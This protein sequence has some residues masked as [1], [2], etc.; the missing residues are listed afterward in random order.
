MAQDSIILQEE[1]LTL[2]C[3]NPAQ[4]HHLRECKVKIFW[5]SCSLFHTFSTLYNL[6]ITDSI[7]FVCNRT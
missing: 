2:H 5:S 4:T 6:R 1:C 3:S 7:L